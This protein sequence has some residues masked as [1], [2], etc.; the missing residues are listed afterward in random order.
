[1][2]ENAQKN[3]SKAYWFR[4][5]RRGRGWGLPGSTP[6]W[7]FFLTWMALLC[8]SVSRLMPQ[9]PVGFIFLFALWSSIYVLVCYTKGEP[10]PP[11][12]SND[13]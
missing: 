3:A 7:I 8:F 5:R 10:L 4:A 1:M 9:H 13:T 12:R 11:G 2:P 6:G